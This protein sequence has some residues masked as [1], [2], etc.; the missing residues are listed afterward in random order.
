MQP[1]LD[2]GTGV[3][4]WFQQFSPT[5]DLPFRG[6]TFLGGEVFFLL[7]L[8]ALYWSVDRRL[9]ARLIVLFLISAYLNAAAKTLAAQPRPFDYDS[10]VKA[11]VHAGSG[12]FPSGHTQH[13]AVVWGYLCASIRRPA[14]CVLAA[15]LMVLVPLSRVYLGVHFPTDL[16]GGYLLGGLLLWL[17]LRLEPSLEAWFRRRG[18]AF[19]AGTAV[20][21]SAAL[22]LAAPAGAPWAM[23]VGGALCGMGTG[24]VLERRLVGFKTAAGTGRRLVRVVTGLS[25]LVLLWS[26]LRL[27][28]DGLHP[29]A[30]FRW[31]RYAAVGMWGALGAPWLFCA[32]GLAERERS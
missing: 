23:S 31:V 18:A 2:W 1:A 12:G 25:V 14:V 20:T 26:G 10:R 8:P 16:L 6:L 24:F 9:G 15:V 3:V 19:Q 30:L 32:V 17:Y 13:T 4:L 29:E 11:L 5:L 7:L 28:F 22:M 27:G 21:V